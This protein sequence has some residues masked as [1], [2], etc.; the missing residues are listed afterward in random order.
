MALLPWPVFYFFSEVFYY[1]VYYLIRYRR[2]TVFS[3][4]KN[5]FPEKQDAEII[6]IQKA[7]YHHFCDFLVESLKTIQLTKNQSDNRFRFSNPQMFQKYYEQG[8]SI[9]LVSGH[10]GNWEWMVHIQEKIRHKFYAIYKPLQNKQHDEL[11]KRIRGKYDAVSQLIP[12]QDVYKHIIA[13]E[14]E[15]QPVIVWFLAD[16]SPPADYPFWIDF[17]YRE[18]PFYNGPE[19][20]AR[21]FDYPVVY[22]SINKTKRGHYTAEFKTLCENSSTTKPG[23]ISGLVVDALEKEIKTKPEYWLWSHKRWKHAREK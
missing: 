10:Y 12:M 6:K 7:F 9:V 22:L 11:I 17:L 23:E 15:K 20:I 5:A 8:K 18:V 3:N 16:Q 1:A 13:F 21:K 4:L 2:Q 19:K 14:K